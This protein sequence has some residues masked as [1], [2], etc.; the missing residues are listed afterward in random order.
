MMEDVNKHY[1]YNED[2][3]SYGPTNSN[4]RKLSSIKRFCI[5]LDSS[6]HQQNK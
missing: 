5:Y 2:I 6:F 1:V 3:E 4:G